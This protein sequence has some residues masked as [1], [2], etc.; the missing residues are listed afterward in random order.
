M[1]LIKAM[2]TG[3]KTLDKA[4]HM[5]AITL[6]NLID[7]LREEAMTIILIIITA[8]GALLTNLTALL[9]LLTI[10][11]DNTPIE[12]NKAHLLIKICITQN[13]T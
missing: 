9:L 11:A 4:I 3:V 13:I 8:V 6:I 7:I 10:K 12:I 1:T 5:D 2:H